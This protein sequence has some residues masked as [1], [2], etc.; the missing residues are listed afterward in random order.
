MT[1][2]TKTLALT[3]AFLL[4]ASAMPLIAGPTTAAAATQLPD[5]TPLAQI[6]TPEQAVT[7]ANVQNLAGRWNTIITG[8]ETGTEMLNAMRDS[9]V[10]ADGTPFT[11]NLPDGNVIAFEGLDDPIAEQFYGQ[12]LEGM[13]KHRHNVTSNVEIVRFTENGAEARFR[14]LVFMGER[15]SLGGIVQASVEDVDG[16]YRF[17]ELTLNIQHF[18]TGHAY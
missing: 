5:G 17:T 10:F 16:R 11:F 9:A 1:L 3:A 13:T 6:E 7:F 14:W 8:A 18:D 12:F 2:R 15:Y 4:G